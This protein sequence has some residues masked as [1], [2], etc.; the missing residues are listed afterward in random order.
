MF[1]P[2][3]NYALVLVVVDLAVLAFAIGWLRRSSQTYALKHISA[4]NTL[5]A[6]RRIHELTSNVAGRVEDHLARVE[7]ISKE[8]VALQTASD[9]PHDAAVVD[10][11]SRIVEENRG[12]AGQLVEAKRKLAEQADTMAA[13]TEAAR[14]DLVT[15]LPNRKGFDDELSR[16]FAQWQEQQVPLSIVMVDVDHLQELQD[17]HGQEAADGVLRGVG[18][19]LADTIRATDLVARY[20]D[21]QFAML[22][23]GTHLAQGKYAV[24][25][26]RG[27]IAA[28]PFVVGGE[29]VKITISE[30]VAEAMA[31]DDIRSLT[32]RTTMALAASRK[33][34]HNC[35]H[36]HDGRQCEAIPIV[37]DSAEALPNLPRDLLR[38]ASQFKAEPAGP[39][40]D[41]LTGLANRRMLFET[42]R[43]RISE[44]N[45]GNSQLTLALVDVDF[46]HHLNQTHGHLV[47]DMVLRVI[48]QIVHT[49]T[50]NRC[51]LAA[52]YEGSR[53]AVIVVGMT[54][55]EAL[56]MAERIRRA[57]AACKLWAE[58]RELKVTVSV[59]LAD[60][61]RGND[62]VALIKSAEIAL[63]A[64]KTS[65][66]NCTQ[67]FSPTAPAVPGTPLGVAG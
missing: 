67:A 59:G 35:A 16:R 42:L 40:N 5:E 49:A 58:G 10:A 66:R 18:Q 2:L 21:D 43:R 19:L 26:F 44:Q 20:S 24:E 62:A 36:C 15:G 65:G 33:A 12:L 39:H 55:V 1:S 7:L 30:G 13:Q 60:S 63:K 4:R 28:H 52:R 48:A 50:R 57:V 27:E 46:M 38:L 22:L 8:L 23:P 53:F 25:R 47:G 34:G 41:P 56:A 11:V 45:V 51:D 64:A 14:A 17:R 29:T 3:I 32:R 37:G 9:S 31:G 6:L 54:P 61:T